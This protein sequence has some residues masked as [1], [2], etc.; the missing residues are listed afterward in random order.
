MRLFIALPLPLKVHE[1]LTLARNALLAHNLPLRVTRADSWHLTL[2]FLGETAETRVAPVC[3]AIDRVAAAREPLTLELA[4]L[5]AFPH[6]SQPQVVWAGIGGDVGG[7]SELRDALAIELKSEGFRRSTQ[8]FKPHVTMARARGRTRERWSA[9][10]REVLKT[11]VRST[12]VEPTS[13]SA[14]GMTLY[15][16]ELHPEG[17]RYTAVY[18][19]VLGSRT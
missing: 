4:G 5:G 11:L 16:S 7:L 2:I 18:T 1:T 12:A 8:L 19:S 15:Q 3:A 17:A 13:W 9:S 14:D 6:L 10:D